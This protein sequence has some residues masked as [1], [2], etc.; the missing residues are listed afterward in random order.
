MS[1]ANERGS[2]TIELAIAAPALL[3]LLGLVIVAGRIQVAASTIEQA[4]A[5]SARA[6]SIARDAR[7]AEAQASQAARDSLASQGI[8][9]DPAT[10]SIDSSGFAVAVGQSAT[11]TARVSCRVPLADLAVP[12]MP[13]TRTVSAEVA[14][15]IDRYRARE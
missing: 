14:S 5:A 11:V 13:G 9:C 4:A 3:A 8:S 7:T 2:A 6:A 1:T 12:G 10:T 15:P